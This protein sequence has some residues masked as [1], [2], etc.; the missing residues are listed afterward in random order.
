M[1]SPNLSELV[2]TTLRNRSR[3]LADNVSDNNALLKRLK[4][5]GRSRPFSGGRN[6]TQEMQY[7]EN[8][9]Y[10]RY[11]GYENLNISPSDVMTAAEYDIKQTAVAVSISGLEMLQNAGREQMID[12]LES[13]I[14]NAELTMMN[15]MSTDIYS[16]GTADSGKQITGLQALIADDPTTGTV[17]GINRAT[18]P[19]WQ[20]KIYDFSDESVTPSATTIQAAMNDLYLNTCRGSD[21]VDLIVADNTYF[22]YYLTSLQSIQRIMTDQTAQ[23]GFMSLKYMGADVIFDGGDGGACPANH[24]YFLNSRY[25]FYRPHSKRNMVPLD[26]DRYA[27]NQDA[28]VKLI[29]WAGNMTMS[30][31]AQQG[32]ILA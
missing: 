9:T 16:D 7:A 20:N 2:T 21:K 4:E 13:R 11:S 32:V 24:M 27:T 10:K 26:P 5:R 15:N 1:A 25:I 3:T 6:I 18:Y 28:M 8:S 30:N 17:G 14:E 19:F 12:L 23:A 29:G 31:A 22:N